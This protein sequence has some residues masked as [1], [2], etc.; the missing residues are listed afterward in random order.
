[1]NDLLD[2][3]NKLH[4]SGETLLKEVLMPILEKYGKVSV[5]GSYAYNLLSHPD[6]DIDIVSD[7]VTKELFAKLSAELLSL[8]HTTNF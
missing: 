6:L 8:Q 1:M 2:K 5:G 7:D 3:Q 4:A